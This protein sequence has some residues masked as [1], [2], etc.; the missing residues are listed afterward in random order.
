MPRF[1]WQILL[2]SLAILL[3]V[4]GTSTDRF[5]VTMAGVLLGVAM[6]GLDYLRD[7][8]RE[9]TWTTDPDTGVR[10]RVT[11]GGDI[12]YHT[13]DVLERYLKQTRANRHPTT[14]H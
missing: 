13:V 14:R 4:V 5:W 7:H 6:L 2:Y 1:F 12:I 10:F 3:A 11:P 9:S 8:G